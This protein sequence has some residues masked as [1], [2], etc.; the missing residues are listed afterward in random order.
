[1]SDFFHS[2]KHRFS[3]CPFILLQDTW[4]NLAYC[5]MVML[6][7]INS[8]TCIRYQAAWT[9]NGILHIT[10][11]FKKIQTIINCLWEIN[12]CEYAP[13]GSSGKPYKLRVINLES[14][15][16]AASW[17]YSNFIHSFLSESDTSQERG[18]CL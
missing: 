11:I 14:W 3:V 17:Q 6:T 10:H 5:F 1:M 13:L 8:Q 12:I 18:M 9:F 7:N 16:R 2:S 15:R 4:N